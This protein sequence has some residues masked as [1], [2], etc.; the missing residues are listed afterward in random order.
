MILGLL[1]IEVLGL[2]LASKDGL[3]DGESDVSSE[4]FE[5]GVENGL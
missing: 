5:E 2:T 3:K 1:E 4:G